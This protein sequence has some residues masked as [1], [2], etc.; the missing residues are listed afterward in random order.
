MICLKRNRLMEFLSINKCSW[1]VQQ[2]FYFP[3]YFYLKIKIYQLI[4]LYISWLTHSYLQTSRKTVFT[5]D[6]KL[7]FSFTHNLK[8]KCYVI[9]S[10]FFHSF[11]RERESGRVHLKGNFTFY[12][13]NYWMLK[14]PFGS[15]SFIFVTYQLFI[16]IRENIT[17]LRKRKMH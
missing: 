17:D 4:S 1:N 15:F 6:H 11:A 9:N 10:F 5:S 7:I 16:N 14:Y 13:L 8:S 2:T 3:P 12:F